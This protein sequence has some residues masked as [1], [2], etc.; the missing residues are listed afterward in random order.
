MLGGYSR[1]SPPALLERRQRICYTVAQMSGVEMVEDLGHGRWPTKVKTVH[2]RLRELGP[3]PHYRR[4]RAQLLQAVGDLTFFL[5]VAIMSLTYLA[6][7]NEALRCPEQRGGAPNASRGW[8]SDRNPDELPPHCAAWSAYAAAIWREAT[9]SPLE[10]GCACFTNFFL[11]SMCGNSPLAWLVGAGFASVTDRQWEGFVQGIVEKWGHPYDGHASYVLGLYVFAAF[12]I[13]YIGHG[14][15]LLPLEIWTPAIEAAAPY[16]IQ[17]KRRVPLHRVVPVM[18][19]SIGHL[20][21]IALP[22]LFAVSHLTVVSRGEHGPRFEGALPRYT[23]RAAMLLLHLLVNEVLFFY[24]H[25]AL[26]TG[27]LYKRIHKQHHEFKAPFALAALYAHPIE[28]MVAD[29]VPF[30]AGF[31][32]FRPHIFFVFMWVVG[33]CLGTQTHHSGYRLPWIAGFDEQPDY[34]DFHHERCNCFFLTLTVTRTLH[35]ALA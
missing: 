9:V 1:W 34:H 13:M 17:G 8:F 5:C 6:L 26:H 11:I 29:L 18:L 19:H 14:L 23:E 16:K 15:L 30:T 27:A 2:D 25:W 10:A 31:L 24:A 32:V 33:A 28:F 3:S 21:T 7:E 22:Y 12:T 4:R 20:L 35:L